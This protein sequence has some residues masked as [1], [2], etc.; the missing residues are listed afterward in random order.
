[1]QFKKNLKEKAEY[2]LLRQRAQ[3][4]LLAPTVQP[5]SYL[6]APGIHVVCMH[7]HRLTFI[8]RVKVTVERL[9]GFECFCPLGESFQSVS[10]AGFSHML[11][12]M[13]LSP[14]LIY[15]SAQ[16]SREIFYPAAYQQVAQKDLAL[17]QVTRG[18]P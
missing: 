6:W 5:P 17:S 16:H 3:V 15:Q 10:P 14:V 4:R 1:M 8:L 12:L 18:H 13:S 2:L 9:P 7:I 11:I